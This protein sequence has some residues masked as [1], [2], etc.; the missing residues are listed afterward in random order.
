MDARII[1]PRLSSRRKQRGFIINPYNYAAGG[2]G[3]GA[4]DPYYANVVL[5]SNLDSGSWVDEKGHTNTQT[6]TVNSVTGYTGCNN[7]AEMAAT[8]TNYVKWAHS[9]GDFTLGTGSWCIEFAIKFSDN[10]IF[11]CLFDMH[12]GAYG[13]NSSEA[14]LI[15]ML[16]GSMRVWNGSDVGDLGTTWTNGTWFRVAICYDGTNLYGYKDGTSVMSIPVSFNLSSATS[17][18]TLGCDTG[19]TIPSRATYDLLR[20]TKHARY[21]NA[22]SITQDAVPYT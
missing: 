19:G 1:P 18:I 2:G 14:V 6:G 8:G 7:G 15:Y 20:V 12:P 13:T 10:S 4:S 22:L 3:F 17:P 5:V 9:G 21:A 11:Q 16:S